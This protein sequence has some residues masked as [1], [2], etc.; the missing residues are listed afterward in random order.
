LENLQGPVQKGFTA[1]EN[2]AA[3]ANVIGSGY[4]YVPYG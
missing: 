2:V 3:V 1:L 4:A